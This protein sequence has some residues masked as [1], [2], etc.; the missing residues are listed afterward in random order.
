MKIVTTGN[1]SRIFTDDLVTSDTLP[2]GYYDVEFNPQTGPYLVR[3]THVKK[4]ERMFGSMQ[5]KV[6]KVLDGYKRTKPPHSYGI[7]LTGR[8][9]TGKTMFARE[10]AQKAGLPVLI[11]SHGFSGMVSFLQSIE[12]EVLVI[13]D[14][15]EKNFTNENDDDRYSQDDLLPLFDGLAGSKK[16][17]VIISNTRSGISN[18]LLGRPGRFHY[19]FYVDSP[20]ED[21]IKEYLDEIIENKEIITEPLVRALSMY[22]LSYDS[23]RAI[24]MELDNGYSLEETIQD[25]N[26]DLDDYSREDNIYIFYTNNPNIVFRCK[27]YS[28]LPRPIS[29]FGQAS[30]VGSNYTN[31]LSFEFNDAIFTPV[32]GKQNTFVHIVDEDDAE[33]EN[34]TF[35]EMPFTYSFD[36]AEYPDDSEEKKTLEDDD[37]VVTRIVAKVLDEDGDKLMFKGLCSNV[38]EKGIGEY[39]K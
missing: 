31:Q 12:Q 13:F 34:R 4:I 33:D 17:Y 22:S 32:K 15:F 29:T 26:L 14:E 8:K 16:F 19:H 25:L 9:G 3:N 2:I 24:A 39:A 38:R 37:L 11:V 27:G 6:N 18:Y 1:I 5:K 21:D 36:T 35:K 28:C 30:L 10:I 20:K 23:L 7:I